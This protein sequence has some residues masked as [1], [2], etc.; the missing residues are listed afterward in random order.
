MAYDKKGSDLQS[1][2]RE[3]EEEVSELHFRVCRAVTAQFDL[4]TFHD[5][6]GW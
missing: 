5:L 2:E 3:G 1:L 4:E 6:R